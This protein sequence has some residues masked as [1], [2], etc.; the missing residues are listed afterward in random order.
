MKTLDEMSE[1]MKTDIETTEFIEAELAILSQAE[2]ELDDLA[3]ETK[4]IKREC[5]SI[6]LSRKPIEADRQRLERHKRMV[7]RAIEGMEECEVR[8]LYRSDLDEI[9]KELKATEAALKEIDRM[10]AKA[11]QAIESCELRIAESR[12]RVAES[13]FEIEDLKRLQTEVVKELAEATG[14]NN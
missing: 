13:R 3:C 12:R 8:E 11:N 6:F 5:R 14:L 1:M 2:S 7:S 10:E 9:E 4:D